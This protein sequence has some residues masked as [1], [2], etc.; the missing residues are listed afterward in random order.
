MP[1]V[2]GYMELSELTLKSK[3]LFKIKC[4]SA[5]KKLECIVL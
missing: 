3:I 5:N 1:N 4:F 2:N